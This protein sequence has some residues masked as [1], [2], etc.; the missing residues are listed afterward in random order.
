V[1]WGGMTR[2]LP[3]L[4]TVALGDDHRER[5]SL[6]LRVRTSEQQCRRHLTGEA[7][8]GMIPR[9]CAPP[10]LDDVRD[11]EPVTVDLH[12]RLGPLGFWIAGVDV[13]PGPDGAT[14]PAP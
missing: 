7:L 3:A 12:G 9:L 2:T 13:P 4:A 10:A 1:L 8:A 5:A 11:H 6:V 14:T